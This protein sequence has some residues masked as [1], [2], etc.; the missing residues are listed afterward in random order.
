MTYEQLESLTILL[1]LSEPRLMRLYPWLGLRSSLMGYRHVNAVSH[2]GKRR[3]W[4]KEKRGKRK[5]D[6]LDKDFRKRLF[7]FEEKS[8]HRL[9]AAGRDGTRREASAARISI[10]KTLLRD[11]HFCA[12]A[13]LYPNS[14]R[15]LHLL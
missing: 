2:N 14:T 9:D 3:M 7:C 10:F 13:C 1:S 15:F 5:I 11:N 4:L 8:K 6:F 12:V